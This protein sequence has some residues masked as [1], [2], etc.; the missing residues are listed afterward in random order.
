MICSELGTMPTE[1]SRHLSQQGRKNWWILLF[2]L[3]RILV[4]SSDFVA[5]WWV[6]R[7]AFRILCIL[8]MN[9]SC[10]KCNL[11]SLTL[12]PVILNKSDHLKWWLGFG[13]LLDYGHLWMSPSLND[14][15]KWEAMLCTPELFP[16]ICLAIHECLW[17]TPGEGWISGIVVTCSVGTFDL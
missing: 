10:Q 3:S 2:E 5:V 11:S 7:S 15:C 17:S 9:M 8:C 14:Q 12:S 13:T 4:Q 16:L 6:P 1:N